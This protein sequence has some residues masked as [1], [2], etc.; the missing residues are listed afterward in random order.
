[1]GGLE[2]GAIIQQIVK[3]GLQP[4]LHEKSEPF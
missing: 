3:P 2:Q 1:L 4:D